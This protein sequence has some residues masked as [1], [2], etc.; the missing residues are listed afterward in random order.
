MR[1]RFVAGNWKMNL[2][3]A[4]ALA[5]TKAIS[6]QE[7][8]QKTEVVI[9][10]PFIYL[11]EL[12]DI[13]S[14]NTQLHIGA[15][16]CHQATSGAYTGEISAQQLKSI[17]TE[18]VIL[19]HS[20]RR[21]FFAETN[22][23]LKEKVDAVLAEDLKVIFCC[24][25]V[26]EER[27]AE[28]QEEVVKTQLREALGHLTADDMG[29]LVIAYEPVWAIGTGKTASAAQAQEIHKTIRLWVAETFGDDIADKIL[30]LYG[31]SCKPNN[32]AELFAQEDVDGGLIGGAS[33]KAEDF[34]QII[35][36]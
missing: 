7:F 8:N 36:A 26:L 27:E 1:S 20:E 11:N 29:D 3:K 4:D 32:A 23:L 22:A 35:N 25:E 18:Y 24:G 9:C 17:G 13:S 33:L 12:S 5:L 31:G 34:L 21:T 28:K 15:Q 16:N 2:S 10:A 6:E 19:G 14:T 30:I